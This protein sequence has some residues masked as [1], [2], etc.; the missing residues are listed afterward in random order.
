[1]F[2]PQKVYKRSLRD[3]YKMFPPDALDLVDRLLT[4]DPHQR[5]SAAEALDS[6]YFWNQPLPCPPSDLPRYP[7]S[8]EFQAK[9]RRSN[10]YANTVSSEQTKR[11]RSLNGVPITSNSMPQPNPSRP[12][13]SYQS[14]P[15]KFNQ[16]NPSS[17][18]PPMNGQ[19]GPP[20]PGNQNRNYPPSTGQGHPQQSSYSRGGS[21]RGRGR[22]MDGRSFDEHPRVNSTPP[23]PSR[24]PSVL[25]PTPTRAP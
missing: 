14:Y 16:G 2:K 19:P 7:S 23:P 5:I 21:F 13:Q 24:G 17:S 9:K 10:Q 20:N 8:H 22:P 6:D 25:G 3:V 15:N 4:L 12:P 1:M 18:Y 11:Q